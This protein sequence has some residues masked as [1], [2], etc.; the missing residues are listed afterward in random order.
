MGLTSFDKELIL[1]HKGDA[2]SVCELGAQNIY[3]GQYPNGTY[4][5][6]FYQS[7]GFNKYVCIDLN[8]ENHARVLDLSLPINLYETF[9][10]VTDFG[11]GE[12]VSLPEAHGFSWEAA[13]NL[14]WN[15]HMLAR[16]GGVIISE[17]PLTGNW[18]GHGVIYHTQEFY[19]EFAK[20]TG[21][22]ILELGLHPAMGNEIDGW[23][24]YCVMQKTE[25]TAFCKKK[26]FMKLNLQPK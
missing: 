8:G 14:W 15:K 19:T 2:K 17:N 6:V 11:T 4:A 21:Y 10:L 18:P 13:F 25:Q 24:V 20:I 7:I 12:H 5:D 16:T 23:N 26:D 1:R 9:D 3:D 22:K